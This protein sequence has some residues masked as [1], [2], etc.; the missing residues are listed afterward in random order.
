MKMLGLMAM[1]PMLIIGFSFL[2]EEVWLYGEF[3]KEGYLTFASVLLAFISGIILLL[4]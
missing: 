2:Y 3:D 4:N 1:M